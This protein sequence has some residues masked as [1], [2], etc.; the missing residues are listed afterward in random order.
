MNKNKLTGSKKSSDLAWEKIVEQPHVSSTTTFFI[1]TR[2]RIIASKIT[3]LKSQQNKLNYKI[4]TY[5]KNPKM[6]K[7]KVKSY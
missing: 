4:K 7:S 6:I 5:N 1:T 2:F 3:S